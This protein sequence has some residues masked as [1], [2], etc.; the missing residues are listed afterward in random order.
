MGEVSYVEARRRLLLRSPLLAIRL[1]WA[2]QRGTWRSRAVP[3]PHA[4]G[5]LQR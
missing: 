4:D 5:A 2:A 3:R 1:F